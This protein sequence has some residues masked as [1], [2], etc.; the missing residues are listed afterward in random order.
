MQSSTRILVI[1]DNAAVREEVADILTFEGFE[2]RQATNGRVGL[3]M[4]R[5]APPDLIICDLMMPEL[6][7]YETL[8]HVRS[9]ATTAAVPF[10][11]L[12]ARAE[13]QALRRA[14][15]GGANDYITKPFT[16]EELLAAIRAALE[17]RERVA[18]VIEADERDLRERLA[19]TL[20][21]ELRTPLHCIMGYAELL[22]DPA[23]I[24]D[25]AE[26]AE[27]AQRIRT[28]GLRL[29][30]LAENFVLYGRL[31]AIGP[32][33]LAT[34]PQ[35]AATAVHLLVA[36]TAERLAAAH[37]RETDVTLD[38]DPVWTP[39]GEEYLRTAV[40][41][42]VDNALKFSGSGSPVHVAAGPQAEHAVIRV[43][44]CGC[45]MRPDQVAAIGAFM[46]FER[47]LREQQGLGLGLSI[48]H[49]IATLMGGGLA[50]EST[51]GS[52]TTVTVTL[53]RAAAAASAHA[54]GG[55]D[56]AVQGQG[57]GR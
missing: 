37:G 18:H 54:A 27:F 52:G 56:G 47:M 32:E 19:A 46:Q 7:G 53:P 50:I 25:P 31:N 29:R 9:D 55:D 34:D 17:K 23:G 8:A 30:R 10:L 38:C 13:R 2:V 22:A 28:A 45:G 51:P 41:E 12:T 36:E 20:P 4:I 43:T 49:R 6:D 40:A 3:E 39:L 35:G 33:A 11:C 48:A 24:A 16:A 1:E 15:E 44:D 57:A 26:V 5:Q 42:L 14:M 21:H